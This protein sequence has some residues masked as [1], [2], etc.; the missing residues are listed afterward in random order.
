MSRVAFDHIPIAES[1]EPLASVEAFGFRGVPVYFHNGWAATPDLYA[2]VGLLDKLARVQ[3]RHLAPRGWQWVVFDAWRPRQVQAAI[4]QHYWR[5]MS[6]QDPTCSR[7]ALEERV[8]TY[9][10]VPAQAHRVPP[11]STGGSLDLGWWDRHTGRLVNMGSGFDEFCP[12]A[13]NDFFEQSGQDADV[14]QRRRELTAWL[15]DEDIASDADEW[16]H[17]DFGNQKWAAQRGHRM[18]H[19]GEVLACLRRGGALEIV[20]GA[21]EPACEKTNRLRMLQEQLDL[22]HPAPQAPRPLPNTAALLAKL[23]Q[24]QVSDCANSEQLGRPRQ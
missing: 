6:A 20:W 5:A 2:R 17:K 10:T 24:P 12:A 1:R 15:V 16:F 8:R 3:A 13:A 18:A 22:V 4:F 9:V 11:H 23:A 14:R 21:D 19:Y 7:E